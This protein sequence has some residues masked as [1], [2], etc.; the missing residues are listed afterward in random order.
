MPSKFELARRR[1]EERRYLRDLQR[2]DE[3]EARRTHNG[4]WWSP[5]F[6]HVWDGG[7]EQRD[8]WVRMHTCLHCGRR[9][10]TY[11]KDNSDGRKYVLWASPVLLG[12]I[13]YCFWGAS[14][15]DPPLT[16]WEVPLTALAAVWGLI[17]LVGILFSTLI[18]S[19]PNGPPGLGD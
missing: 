1:R 15:T 9:A 13:L 3:R 2:E 7:E 10:D 8:T 16:G 12:G 18:L 14:Y 4:C 19:G 17:S 11:D 5:P 6:G